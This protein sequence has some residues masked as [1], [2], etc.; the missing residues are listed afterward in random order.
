MLV[1]YILGLLHYSYARAYWHNGVI[2]S[3][4]KAVKSGINTDKEVKALIE[5]KGNEIHILVRGN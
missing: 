5:I 4:E 1:C 3:T 2:I